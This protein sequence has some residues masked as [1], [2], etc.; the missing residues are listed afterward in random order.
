M[1]RKKSLKRYILIRL[2]VPLMFF[3]TGESVLSYFVTLHYVDKTYDRWLLDTAKALAQEIK[4]TGTHIRVEL[5]PAAQEIV[6]WDDLDKTYFKI[7]SLDKGLL[8]GDNIVPDAPTPATDQTNPVFFNGVIQ[9]ESVRLLTMR[10]DKSETHDTF[11]VHV[12]ET[13]NK[14]REMMRDILLADL[15]PQVLLMLISCLMLLAGVKRGL[16]PLHVL[17]GE[18]DKRSPHDLSPIADT[19]VFSEIRTLTDT[20]NGLLQRLKESI[21]AQQRFIANAAHQLR[22]PL[23]GFVVQTE[24]ATRENDLQAMKPALSQMQKSAH[25]LSHTV[26]QLL[27]LAKSEPVDGMNEFK[28][29]DLTRLVKSI[30]IEWAPKALKRG[31]EIGFESPGKPVY[32]QGDET[33]LQ[34]LV[35]NLLDNAVT[36]GKDRGHIGIA[37]TAGPNPAL[38]IED[39]GPGIAS[40]EQS[41]I[42]ERFYRIPG[43]PGNGC[44]LGL[45]IVKEIADLHN[46]GLTL[47]RKNAD[48]GTRITLVFN[49]PNGIDQTALGIKR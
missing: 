41:R 8:A 27:V 32:V 5:P 23:A 6:K 38:T 43:S 14:R 30:C 48:G 22:T 31:I 20:I 28:R 25:R 35:V 13:L 17:A 24:R 46:A 45:A 1:P 33:L 36:Y 12:G 4:T 47:S 40:H 19:H 42:F 2:I 18:I 37:L 29:I 15:L 39:D 10:V 7:N 49:G 16:K 26:A 21:T 9:G 34:E 3:I 44:G 11:F